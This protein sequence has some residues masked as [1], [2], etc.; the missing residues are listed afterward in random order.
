MT[1]VAAGVP[2]YV[3]ELSTG[4]PLKVLPEAL[5]ASDQG[6]DRFVFG[7]YCDGRILPLGGAAGS[8]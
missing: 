6:Q 5:A 1:R 7:E 4:V 2:K 3:P 8:H